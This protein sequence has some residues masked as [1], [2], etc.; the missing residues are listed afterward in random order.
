MR[1]SRDQMLIEVGHRALEDM[2][3]ISESYTEQ[4]ALKDRAVEITTWVLNLFFHFSV[5]ILSS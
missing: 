3:T 2:S 1:P 5:P 4:V